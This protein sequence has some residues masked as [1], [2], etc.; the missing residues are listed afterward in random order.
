MPRPL[1]GSHRVRDDQ[2]YLRFRGQEW[3][4]GPRSEWPDTKIAAELDRVV[5]SYKAG[6]WQGPRPEAPSTNGSDRGPLFQTEASAY[7]EDQASRGLSKSSRDVL[8]WRVDHLLS[9]FGQ[10]A[11]GEPR[12][13]HDL[14]DLGLLKAYRAHKVSEAEHLR[15]I[16]ERH[17]AGDPTLTDAERALVRSRVKGL[18]AQSINKTL[19]TLGNIIERYQQRV[20]G[21][22]PANHARSK[23]LKMVVRKRRSRTYLEPDQVQAL[24]DGAQQLEEEARADRATLGRFEMLATLVCTGIR[25]QE[26]CDLTRANVNLQ[27]SKLIV[28][29]SKTEAGVREVWFSKF[30]ADVLSRWMNVRQTT[31][32]SPDDP[33]FPTTKGGRR[34]EDRF[35]DRILGTALC[36]ADALLA[37]QGYSPMPEQVTPHALRRT[38]VTYAGEAGFSLRY[39]MNQVGHVDPEMTVGV[40]NQLMAGR[41]DPRIPVWVADTPARQRGSGRTDLGIAR[42]GLPSGVR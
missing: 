14:N 4:A 7:L 20:P 11:K 16:R 40:Y 29:D 22:I 3:R 37:E 38:Y 26:M 13:M 21:A 6:V 18:S 35:R 2:V 41:D 36:R 27:A 5:S 17:A 15:E 30:L 28:T 25:I 23:D 42:T 1:K 24:F 39:V 10:D 32:A 34:D 12:R 8:T 9:F 19:V 33:L 31:Y